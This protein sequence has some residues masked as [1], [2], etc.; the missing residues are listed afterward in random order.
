MASSAYNFKT[1]VTHLTWLNMSIL[2]VPA[3]VVK[4]LGGVS[5]QRWICTA[6]KT[7]SWQCGLVALGKGKAYI[8]L[9]KK[10]LKEMEVKEGDE[11]SVSLKIDESEYGMKMS[12]ELKELLSQ[13]KEGKKRYD[14]LVPGKQRFELLKI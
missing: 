4:K 3:I 14:G 2:E 12:A 8:N 7:V 11:V 13:D 10:L 6:N 9:N 5:K 1:Y